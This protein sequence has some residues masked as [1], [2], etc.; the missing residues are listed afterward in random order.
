VRLRWVVPLIFTA[1]AGCA[2]THSLKTTSA[3]VTID[4]EPGV[5][6]TANLSCTGGGSTT[7][8]GTGGTTIRGYDCAAI[9]KDGGSGRLCA[10]TIV[11]GLGGEEACT[12]TPN[13]SVTVCGRSEPS[14]ASDVYSHASISSNPSRSRPAAPRSNFHP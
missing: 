5:S 12:E 11:G 13:G 3:Y 7:I 6:W 1:V 2:T 9:W 8:T 14:P 10:N 4:A